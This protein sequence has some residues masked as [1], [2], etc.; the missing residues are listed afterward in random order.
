[1]SEVQAV[2]GPLDTAALGATLMHEHI[3]VVDPDVL[4][5]FPTDFDPERAVPEAAG[6]LDELKAAGI[7]TIVDVTTLG[8]GRNIRLIQAVAERTGLNILV[9]T[10]IYIFDHLPHYF[11]CRDLARREDSPD[12]LI[13]SFVRDIEEGILDTGVRAALLKCATDANGVTPDV[14][15]VLRA[16]AK[17]HLATGAPIT[18]HTDVAARTGLVQQ[19]V[20]AQE[21]V[22]L[23]RVII[24]HC[25]D[26][27]D[28]GYL[29]DL[30]AN[31][32]YL[33]MDRFGIEDDLSDELRTRTVAE[34]CARGYAD[35][36]VLSHDASVCIDWYDPSY[37]QRTYPHWH[38][39]HVP[40]DIVPALKRLG[41]SDAQVRAML[42][43]NPQRIFEHRGGQ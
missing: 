5:N 16:V 36:L 40:H 10:G 11:H 18:T 30:L 6:R 23:S 8:T 2:S 25:G 31:G 38:F 37:Q 27:T 28:L 12:P 39:L 43:E 22:D 19:A 7:D 9:A 26:T 32:S 24:G 13:A 35:R 1:M 41:V 34:L 15:R 42:V 4:N 3:F 17:A 20:F 29:E 14:E 21:G 33:G